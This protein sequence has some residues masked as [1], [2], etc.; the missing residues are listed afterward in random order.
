[1]RKNNLKQLIFTWTGT[2]LDQLRLRLSRPDALIL[3]SLLGLLTGLFAGGLIVLFRLVVEQSQSSF[4]PMGLPENYE[5]LD[6]W[7]RFLLPLAGALIIAWVFQHFSKGTTVLGVSYVMERM[8]Y[9]QGYLTLRGMLL[10]FVGATVAI[11]SGHSVGR[12]GPHI[13]LGAATGSLLGQYLTLPNNSIRTLLG[14]G[15]AAGIAASFNTPLAGVIFSLEVVMME[16]SLTSF[17]PVILAAVAATGVSILAFG[18]TPAFEVPALVMGSLSDIPLVLLLGFLIG[19]VAALFIYLMKQV[20]GRVSGVAFWQRV[21][22]AGG[23]LGVCGVLVPQVMGI[24]YDTVNSALLGDIGLGLLVMIL[25]VK[26]VA[27]V[28]SLG[29]GIPGGNIGPLLFI[30]ACVGSLTGQVATTIFQHNTL[31]VGF[32]A[33]LG[34]GAMMGATLQAPLAAL[35]AM[36]ELTHSPQI[37]MPGML[38]IV[39]AALT[40]RVLFRQESLFLALLK[41]MGMDFDTNPVMLALRR[42]GVASVMQ[43]RFVRLDVVITREKAKAVLNSEPEWLL[44]D[45]EKE[46]LGVNVG[47]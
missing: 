22:W 16:Y 33:L 3:L 4:L 10:Q 47:C 1:M 12:E 15:T 8:A 39:V 18:N 43:K 37:I 29:L 44:I 42:S 30:G 34:M 32:Y 13:L 45:G 25:L 2:R 21:L 11:I 9:H 6:P 40:S 28:S 24:G 19:A 27:T 36:M 26:I 41:A 20:A 14:C 35:T 17:I 5:G 38:A 31:D 46:P 7:M 23:L